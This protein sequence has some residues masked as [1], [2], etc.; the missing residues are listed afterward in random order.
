MYD[1]I[2]LTAEVKLLYLTFPADSKRRP[3]PSQ[4]RLSSDSIHIM[5]HV[6]QSSFLTAH[7]YST[8]DSS[9]RE[10]TQHPF[11]VKA[12][13]GTLSASTLSKW[14]VQDKYYQLAYVNFIGGLIAKLPL[15]SCVF[16]N[17]GQDKLTWK[18]LDMLIIALT[19]IRQEIEFY[20]KTVDKYNLPI[21]EAPPNDATSQYIKLFEDASAKGTP[22]IHGLVVLW[23]TEQV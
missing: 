21:E 3:N 9:M 19:N 15:A 22:I 2:L 7:L 14:L 4:L 8:N 11:L 12:G 20:D 18:T 17:S 13:N 1:V 5:A 16:P 23:A 10:A 6:K